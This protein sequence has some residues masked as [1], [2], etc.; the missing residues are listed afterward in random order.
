V[1]LHILVC[2]NDET[3][4]KT[5]A[6]V[7]ESAG[8]Q[9]KVKL[10]ISHLKKVVDQHRA[11]YLTVLCHSLAEGETEEALRYISHAMPSSKALVL[12]VGE[13]RSASP[14]TASLNAFDGPGAL[15]ATV[16]GLSA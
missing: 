8:F 1:E 9:V 2:G 11:T 10:G 15:I 12:T 16:N 13:P 14:T 7:L 4:L 6:L 5:R 3:L